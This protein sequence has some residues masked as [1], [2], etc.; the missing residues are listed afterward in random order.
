M[1]I[2]MRSF[3][4]VNVDSAEDMFS[5][6]V[7]SD[8]GEREKYMDDGNEFRALLTNLHKIFDCTDYKVLINKLS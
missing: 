7:A 5:A 2:L 1:I 6:L 4:R 8:I 3:S